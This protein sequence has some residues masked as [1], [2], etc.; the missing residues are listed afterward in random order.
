MDG[1]SFPAKLD[2]AGSLM[3]EVKDGKGFFRWRK[4][5]LTNGSAG[6]DVIVLEDVSEIQ[7][8]KER[9]E[10]DE[11]LRAMGEMAARI[12]HEIKNPLGSCSSSFP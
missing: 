3:G 7:K 1:P 4:S 12:A 5:G 9:S 8:M 6:K 10:R 2:R 11:R